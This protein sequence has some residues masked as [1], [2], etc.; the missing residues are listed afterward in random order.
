MDLKFIK[1][2]TKWI[3]ISRFTELPG[4]ELARPVV[5]RI[6]NMPPNHKV[7][8][9]QHDWGQIAFASKGILTITLPD[10]R[11]I[12]PPERALWIPKNVSH[13]VSTRYGAHFRSLYV[14]R[15]WSKQ[16]PNTSYVFTVSNLLRELILAITELPENYDTSGRN[17]YLLDLLLEEIKNAP[18]TP[19]F[20]PFPT[21]SRL[22][23]I[24]N[25]LQT[26]PADNTPLE[27]WQHIAGASVRTINRLFNKETGMGFSQWRQRLRIFYALEQLSHGKSVT[28][29]AMDIGYES[30]SAFITMFKKQ[31]GVSPKIYLNQ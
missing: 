8:P 22:L 26:S 21:D 3:S 5:A 2:D 31:L 18:S 6:G 9:H 24:C 25:H 12:V 23:N 7:Q 16:L 28:A 29:V 4:S 20:I 14:G 17:Q 1:S 10:G 11:Y 19:L 13:E 30:P 15:E 27:Q